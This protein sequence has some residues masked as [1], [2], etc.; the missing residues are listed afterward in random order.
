MVL[1]DSSDSDQV[2]VGWDGYQDS[3]AQGQPLSG[4]GQPG[5][6]VGG[7]RVG[8]TSR[9]LLEV[10]AFVLAGRGHAFI[11]VSGKWDDAH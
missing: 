10:G 9:G 2:G 6:S 3:P 8:K 5:N 4:T 11:L 1:W 7:S